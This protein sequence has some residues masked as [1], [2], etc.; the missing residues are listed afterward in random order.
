[1][2][3]ENIKQLIFK[4]TWKFLST[5][6]YR[7]E[8]RRKKINLFINLFENLKNLQ[9]VIFDISN[10][11]YDELEQDHIITLNQF[12]YDLT[13]KFPNLKIFI[14]LDCINDILNSAQHPFRL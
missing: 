5:Y 1:M 6:T 8:S 11:I 7:E 13:K 12:I 4:D 9:S 3:N 10:I 2:F 14:K